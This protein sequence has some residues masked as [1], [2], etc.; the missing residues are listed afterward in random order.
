MKTTRLSISKLII[1]MFIFV[2]C[3]PTPDKPAVMNRDDDTIL[4]EV[5][6][7]IVVQEKEVWEETIELKDGTTSLFIEAEILPSTARKYPV[8]LI[9][10]SDFTVEQATKAVDI[11]MEG[12]PIFE[13]KTVATKSELNKEIESLKLELS[14]PKQYG[15]D[16]LND[17]DPRIVEETRKS[18]EQRIKTVE[19]LLE[20]AP[21]EYSRMPAS[22]EFKPSSYYE[23]IVDKEQM[24]HGAQWSDNDSDYIERKE[25]TQQ[26]IL[27]ADLDGGYYGRISIKNYT[28]ESE[29]HHTMH[30]I[31]SSNPF[32]GVNTDFGLVDLGAAPAIT[33]T[34]EQAKELVLDTVSAL[35][36]EQWVVT[37]V[38]PQRKN[39]INP[40]GNP[41]ENA[42]IT[43]YNFELQRVYEG[44]PTSFRDI[45]SYIWTYKTNS[46]MNQMEDYKYFYEPERINAVVSEEGLVY[47]SWLE[48]TQVEQIENENVTILEIDDV[49]NAIRDYCTQRYNKTSYEGEFQNRSDSLL[50]ITVHITSVEMGMFRVDV[51]DNSQLYRLLPAW[52]VY[53][54]VSYD[55]QSHSVAEEVGRPLFALSAL[56]GR[57]IGIEM[58]SNRI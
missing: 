6:E 55:D 10:P 19:R 14:N 47:L 21:D 31:K 1:V 58:F 26:L 34:E 57:P 30:F 28:N 12:K 9:K 18:Y 32:I 8:L 23:D 22:I 44:T 38:L 15:G 51:R 5:A 43:G 52:T 37:H 11:L 39:V 24:A 49:K 27:D 20:N 46:R 48:Q 16:G 45:Q 50:N 40:D 53:G 13:P 25:S 3:Q 54:T 17:D 41:D 33:I 4:H 36:S 56:D 7:T 2:G 29:W 42:E 35:D